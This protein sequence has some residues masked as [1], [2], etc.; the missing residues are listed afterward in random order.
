[1][2]GLCGSLPATANPEMLQPETKILELTRPS[3]RGNLAQRPKDTPSQDLLCVRD[4]GADRLP[5]LG[6][7]EKYNCFRSVKPMY[8]PLQKLLE[9][10]RTF[11]DTEV[12]TLHAQ[13]DSLTEDGRIAL[14]S[15]IKRRGLGNAQLSKLHA[16]ELRREA[17]FDQ[18]Q[19][20]HRKWVASDLLQGNPF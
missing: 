7:F 6:S 5:A 10:Y 19:G 16:S 17:K 2:Q 12:A 3:G 8:V 14:A 9:S 18:Q 11:S 15:E 1:M 4:Q 13:T 20:E